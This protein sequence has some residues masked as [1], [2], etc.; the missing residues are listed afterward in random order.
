VPSP[1]Y[2]RADA[3][4]HTDLATS[5]LDDG[6]A[7]NISAWQQALGLGSIPNGL[8]TNRPTMGTAS[9]FYYATD[10]GTL[11][12]WNGAA[13]TAVTFGGAG[14]NTPNTFTQPQTLPVIDKGGQQFNIAGYGTIDQTGAADSSVAFA[15][16][17]VAATPGGTVLH[18]GGLLKI[19]TWPSIPKTVSLIGI[20]ASTANTAY[21][22]DASYA[23]P[24]R[25]LFPGSWFICPATSGDVVVLPGTGP[26]TRLRGVGFIGPGSGTSVGIHIGTQANGTQGWVWDDVWVRNFATGVHFDNAESGHCG[27]IYIAGCTQGALLD[28]ATNA[29]DFDSFNVTQCGSVSVPA[30]RFKGATL[31][32]IHG[33]SIQGNCPSGGTVVQLDTAGA[34]GNVIHAYFENAGATWDVDAQVGGDYTSLDRCVLQGNVRF[35]APNCSLTVGAGGPAALTLAGANPVIIGTLAG[36][37]LTD[38]TSTSLFLSGGAAPVRAMGAVTAVVNAAGA[39]G[40][41]IHERNGTAE[42]DWYQI[43]GANTLYFRD[44]INAMGV[45]EFAPNQQWLYSYYQ[46]VLAAGIT[47]GY[48]PKTSNYALTVTDDVVVFNGSTLTATVPNPAATNAGFTVVVKNINASP[49]TVVSAVGTIDGASSIS[50]PQWGTLTLVGDGGS[51]WYSTAGSTTKALFTTATDQTGSRALN[52]DYTAGI[53][54]RTVHVTVTCAATIANAAT[55]GY[56]TTIGGTNFDFANDVGANA[57]VIVSGNYQMT[58]E[59]DPGGTYAVNSA[60][61][62]SSTVTLLRWVEVDQ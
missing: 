47:H 62:G 8:A 51:H 49:L 24:T 59:V 48:S 45:L 11:Y 46:L 9:P 10:T 28:N 20:G 61:G 2:G 29:N 15:A 37:V 1:P 52:T 44:L 13:W 55:A 56:E 26:S 3:I 60:V 12:F 25:T 23:S 22:G 40:S 38:N 35:T 34:Q 7:A 58:F 27:Y 33:G 6:V 18:P 42:W 53:Y 14:L 5:R 17:V 32:R 36:T 54:R 16:A 57:G 50:L 30:V 39:G 41:F 43:P 31:N 4:V 21:F 19:V